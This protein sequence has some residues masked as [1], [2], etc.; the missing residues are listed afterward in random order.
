MY[1]YDTIG[2]GTDLG[3]FDLPDPNQFV[4]G[5]EFDAGGAAVP[6]PTS[7]VLLGTVALAVAGIRRRLHVRR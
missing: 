1:H 7:I 6:E 3:F 2:N 5:L 4:D